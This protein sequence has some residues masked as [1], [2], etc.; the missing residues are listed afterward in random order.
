M[1]FFFQCCI[2][3]ILNVELEQGAQPAAV[4]QAMERV[5]ADYGDG[6]D[7]DIDEIQGIL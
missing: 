7:D 6:T 2:L 4:P 1:L 3:L 5:Q